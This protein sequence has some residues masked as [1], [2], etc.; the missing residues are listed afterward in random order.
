MVNIRDDWKLAPRSK[1]FS[2]SQLLLGVTIDNLFRKHSV[3]RVLFVTLTFAKPTSSVESAKKRFASF[4]NQIRKRYSGYLWVMEPH[5]S[6]KIHYHLLIPSGFNAHE[7]TDVFEWAEDFLTV[8]QRK[9][10]MNPKLRTESDWWEAK[11]KNYGFGVS[12]V[13]PVYSTAEALRKYCTKQGW[14]NS[15]WDYE[16]MSGF[17]FW[18]CSTEFKSGSVKFSWNTTGGVRWRQFLATWA[19]ERGCLSIDELSERVGSNWG[20]VLKLEMERATAQ[21]QIRTQGSGD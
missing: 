4:L 10:F 11:V 12:E 5:A 3:E 8:D 15:F 18:G 19:A 9:R 14:T 2:K 16:D 7:G 21:A 17:R 1:S 6:G 13:A 20:Y